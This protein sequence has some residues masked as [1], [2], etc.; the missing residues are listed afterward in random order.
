MK[1]IAISEMVNGAEIKQFFILDKKEERV[2]KRGDPFWDV[3][4]SDATGKIKGKVWSDTINRCQ[5]D[6]TPG[7]IVGV[8]GTVQVY[9][10]EPQLTI[11][12]MADVENIKEQGG[13]VLPWT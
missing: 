10:E 5:K 13:D 3:T 9:Q 7:S 8:R 6:L 4:L 11:T 2:T 12:Y 1:H